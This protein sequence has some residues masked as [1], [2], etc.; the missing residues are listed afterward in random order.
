VWRGVK[1]KSFH[2]WAELQDTIEAAY[3]LS[4]DEMLDAFYAMQPAQGE[5]DAAF[6]LR[7][8]EKMPRLKVDGPAALRHFAPMLSLEGRRKIDTFRST[9]VALGGAGTQMSW[10]NLVE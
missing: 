9:L 3:G 4:E 6:I 5:S 2:S 8:N 7:V 10:D 1:H